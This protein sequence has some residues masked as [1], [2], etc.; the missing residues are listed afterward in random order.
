MKAPTKITTLYIDFDAFFAN[1]EKQLCPE[2]AHRPVGVSA[3]PSEHSA[4]IAQCYVAKAHGLYRGINVKEAKALCPNL[5]VISARHDVYVE[6]HHKIIRAIETHLPVKKVWSVDEME[7][8]FGSLSDKSCIRIARDIRAQIH[9]D[10]GAYVTPSIGLSSSNLLAKI[11]AEMNKPNAFEILHPKDLPGRLLEVPLRDV[12]G[13]ASGIEKRL[14]AAGIYTMEELWHSSPKQARAIWHSVEG[15]RVWWMLH[16]YP[17][18]KAP[19]KRAMYGH[20]RQL[21]GEWTSKKRAEDCLRLLA[22]QAAR[23]MRKDG[24]VA[25]K[26]SVSIKDQRK[27]RWSAELHTTPIRDDYSVLRLTRRAYGVCLRQ[28]DIRAVRQVYITLHGLTRDGAFSD[29]FF[30]AE[31]DM[32]QRQKLS[33]LSDAIDATNLK[34][35]SDVL[36]VGLQEQPPGDYA[37]GKIAFGRIPDAMAFAKRVQAQAEDGARKG[38]KTG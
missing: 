34:Y 4:I 35:Q 26:L 5:R 33:R 10:I 20:S 28:G 8:D 17:V 27:E 1:V 18:E 23:R 24:F 29:H 11:A 37:G 2:E 25:T 19:T 14:N 3:F 22:C 16:G 38:R 21:S 6:M 32:A 36:T 30:Q 7:C 15:E 9:Q 12:P 31:T 13:I